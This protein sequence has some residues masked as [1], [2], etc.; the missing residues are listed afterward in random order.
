MYLQQEMWMIEVFETPLAQKKN[1]DWGV[2]PFEQMVESVESD[3]VPKQ[4][5]EWFLCGPES[6]LLV[7]LDVLTELE[8]RNLL[9]KIDSEML[10]CQF[11]PLDRQ[12]LSVWYPTHHLLMTERKH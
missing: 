8:M 3:P 7:E 11:A 4:P 6:I 10:L 1:V 5:I 12:T 9:S 2:I